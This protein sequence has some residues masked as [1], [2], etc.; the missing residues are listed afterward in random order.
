MIRSGFTLIQMIGGCF[1]PKEWSDSHEDGNREVSVFTTSMIDDW[2]W[3][4]LQIVG[5]CFTPK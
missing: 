2:M 1:T 5:G 3:V 4:Y